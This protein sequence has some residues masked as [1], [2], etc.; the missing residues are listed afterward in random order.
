[1]K[2]LQK[3]KNRIILAVT[4]I[5]ITIFSTE[6]AYADDIFGIG[7]S[8]SKS[9]NNWFKKFVYGNNEVCNISFQ[10]YF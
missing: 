6:T 3:N 2:T 4:V 5:I 10:R 8:I 7:D 1:M 9:I